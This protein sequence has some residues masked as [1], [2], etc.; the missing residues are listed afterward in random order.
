[1]DPTLRACV[2]DKPL[3]GDFQGRA[4]SRQSDVYTFWGSQSP[5]LCGFLEGQQTINSQYYC[6]KLENKA[7]PAIRTKRHRLLAKGVIL[8]H[9]K[10][11]PVPHIPQTT[12]ECIQEL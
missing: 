11:R 12:Q 10:A 8:L 5:I 4:I 2:E 9:D 1:M 3:S 6:N 7:N